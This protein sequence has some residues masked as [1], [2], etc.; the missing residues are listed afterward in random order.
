MIV[1]TLA[2][3][4]T[5]RVIARAVALIA[6]AFDLVAAWLDHGDG[7]V[8]IA[9]G[10]AALVTAIALVPCALS[11]VLAVAE[12]MRRPAG[13]GRLGVDAMRLP[14]VVPRPYVG[15]AVLGGIATLAA[16]GEGFGL[17]IFLAGIA[18]IALALSQAA[19]RRQIRR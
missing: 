9:I 14:I 6:V 3:R 2:P 10:R 7:R 18:L 4:S 12:Q 8:H 15:A 11:F 19:P 5:M 16:M 13:A 17:Y 1:A